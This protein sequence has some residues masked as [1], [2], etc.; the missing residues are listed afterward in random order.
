MAFGIENMEFRNIILFDD[1]HNFE[2]LS[3]VPRAVHFSTEGLPQPCV[4]DFY[5]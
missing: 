1:L 3:F 4:G 2:Q 5:S